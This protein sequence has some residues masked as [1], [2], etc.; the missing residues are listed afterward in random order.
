VRLHHYVSFV[1][2]SLLILRISVRVSKN[3]R[4]RTNENI[5]ESKKRG[6]SEAKTEY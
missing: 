1:N 3:I 5:F 4:I 2:G 6:K